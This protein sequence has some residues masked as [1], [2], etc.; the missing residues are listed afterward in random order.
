VVPGIGGSLPPNLDPQHLDELIAFLTKRGVDPSTLQ[1]DPY[2][3]TYD[4]LINNLTSQGYVNNQDLFQAAYD[5]RLPLAP[6]NTAFDG[7]I[8]GLTAQS[9]TGGVFTYGVDYLGYWLKQAALAWIKVHPGQPLGAVDI[10]AHSMGALLTRAYI[11]SDAYGGTFTDAA[12]NQTLPLPKINSFVMVAAPTLGASEPWNLVNNNFISLAGSQTTGLIKQ[13]FDLVYT[14]VVDNA[15]TIAGPTLITRASITNPTTGQPD[16][17]LFIEQYVPTFRMLMATYPF[18]K[19]HGEN[20]DQPID[21]NTE[22]QR[23][24]FLLDVNGGPD[25]NAFAALVG[26]L[27]GVYGT[28]LSTPTFATRHEG[29]GGMVWPLD[30]NNPGSP[31]R[32]TNPGEVW[33]S[34]DAQVGG[35]G[36]VPL[37]S[38]EATFRGDPRVHLFPQTTGDVSHNGLLN[39]Q[40][41]LGLVDSLLVQRFFAVGGAPGRVL[42]YR[43]DNTL[44]ADF[45][46]YGAAYTGPISVAV[47]DVSGGNYDLVTGAAVGN[48]DVRVYDGTAFVTSTFNP[49]NPDASLLAQWFPYDLNFNVGAN[50]AVG[51]IEKD[52][53]AD[54]VTGTTA[55]NPDVRVYRGKDIAIGTFEP[56][57]ASLVAQWFPYA[58]EFNV[59]ANVAVG[60]ISR[61]GYADVVTGPTAGNPD[62]RVY[63]GQDI[64]KGQFHPTGSSLLAQWFAYGL[65]FNVG[66]FVAV[67]D[68]NGDGFG[69]VIT[70]A[71][72]GNP[73]VRVYDGKAIASGVFDGNHPENSQ[74]TQFFAYD[75]A[76]NVGAAVAAADLESNGKFDILT[77]ASSGPPHYRV[78]RGNA[79]G[80]MPPALFEGIPTDLQGGIAVGA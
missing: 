57:G 31:P 64:A 46:P 77:G 1:L 12:T 48:P 3:H 14:A 53:Y 78:V 30:S 17:L 34:D 73:D 13:G 41:V 27:S 44:V 61:N 74:L 22:P 65:N 58:L 4:N 10:V 70:G 15:A 56:T 72:A 80:I 25:P 50:V 29:Q 60:D 47:G 42:V 32:P 6:T 11:Q 39:N 8:Y 69:D 21:V 54:I 7:H 62:V 49:A 19:I 28:T 71:T 52:G 68:T 33:Y 51:D 79:T 67:G 16:P 18:L 36:T 63:N 55:G 20:N 23:S 66:A 43:P 26:N 38:L 24:D 59:G 5:W 9:I 40:R 75:L 37:I 76:F 2:R 35:D 45:A